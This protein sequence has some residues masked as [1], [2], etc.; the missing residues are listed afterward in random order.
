MSCDTNL[1]QIPS[2]KDLRPEDATH[3]R[4]QGTQVN[5]NDGHGGSEIR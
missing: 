4:V 2:A 1:H 5:P 3:N